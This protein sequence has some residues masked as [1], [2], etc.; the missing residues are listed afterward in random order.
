[1]VVVGHWAEELWVTGSARLERGWSVEACLGCEYRWRTVAG[2]G[3]T[4]DGKGEL[5]GWLFGWKGEE[6]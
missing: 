6:E 2:R 1:M 3:G 4:E 5:A